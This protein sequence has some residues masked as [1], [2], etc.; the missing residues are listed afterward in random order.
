MSLMVNVIVCMWKEVLESIL[1]SGHKTLALA[2][3]T[4]RVIAGKILEIVRIVIRWGRDSYS[5]H[6]ASCAHAS[7]KHPQDFTVL[8]HIQTY[9]FSIP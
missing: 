7:I 4:T 6:L 8:R 5:H 3:A 9:V 1:H 2:C